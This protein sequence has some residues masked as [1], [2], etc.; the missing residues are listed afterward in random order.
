MPV[1]QRHNGNIFAGFGRGA[2]GAWSTAEEPEADGR[3]LWSSIV[4]MNSSPDM[5]G[6]TT[7]L[8][9]ENFNADL[10]LVMAFGHLQRPPLK[11]G[12]VDIIVGIGWITHIHAGC[13]CF[14]V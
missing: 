9:C 4:L 2:P 10:N 8:F 1:P 3:L 12:G 13:V 6:Q 14:C 5:S 11:W 7:S